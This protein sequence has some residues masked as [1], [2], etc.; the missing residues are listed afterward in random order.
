MLP[1][2]TRIA[3]VVTASA[4][5]ATPPESKSGAR[6]RASTSAAIPHAVAGAPNSKGNFLRRKN[7]AMKDA[8]NIK[9]EKSHAM[10]AQREITIISAPHTS[11]NPRQEFSART[12]RGMEGNWPR[13]VLKLS[14][15]YKS[16]NGKG[17]C[18]GHERRHGALRCRIRAQA[19]RGAGHGH[20]PRR[21]NARRHLRKN[22][23]HPVRYN[24]I[25][26]GEKGDKKKQARCH[27]AAGG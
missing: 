25:R 17:S 8:A 21:E 20:N 11:P 6:T 26:F 3:V 10:P 23:L 12:I 16:S 15:P 27:R 14:L 18:Y 5:A 22:P 13:T 7:A 2:S 19:G 24:K 9:G 4:E 1:S